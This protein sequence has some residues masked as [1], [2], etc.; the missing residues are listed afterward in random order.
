MRPQPMQAFPV[1]QGSRS[2]QAPQQRQQSPQS[3][4]SIRNVPYGFSADALV[5]L[6]DGAGQLQEQYDFLLLTYLEELD[7]WWAIVNFT[8]Q[9]AA[10]Q[11]KAWLH[12]Q[13]WANLLGMRGSGDG[14]A[15]VIA[16]ET[17]GRAALQ[18]V[19]GASSPAF[20][21]SPRR[22]QHV[23]AEQPSF[24][25]DNFAPDP[26]FRQ[27][28]M[29]LP[30]RSVS[31]AGGFADTH[32]SRVVSSSGGPQQGGRGRGRDV[33]RPQYRGESAQSQRPQA[34]PPLSRPQPHMQ[35]H[36]ASPRHAQSSR[37]EHAPQPRPVHS[38]R[39]EPAAQAKAAS[40][41]RPH[42]AQLPAK[43]GSRASAQRPPQ[44]AAPVR[45]K[46]QRSPEHRS[47][48]SASGG[49]KRKITPIV[50][51]RSDGA[52]A[53]ASDD[54]AAE[55]MPSKRPR[56]AAEPRR[57][58]DRPA[59]AQHAAA[60]PM[61]HKQSAAAGQS[62]PSGAQQAA[63]PSSVRPISPSGSKQ[64]QQRHGSPDAVEP[65]ANGHA[66]PKPES[67]HPHPPQQP[68]VHMP[69]ASIDAIMDS[70]EQ[71]APAP[72]QQREAQHRATADSSAPVPGSPPA[73][74]L[75]AQP[76]QAEGSLCVS[77]ID[78]R[79]HAAAGADANVE[80][81]EAPAD[82]PASIQE[83][84]GAMLASNAAAAAGKPAADVH[85][86]VTVIASGA[87]P[88]SFGEDFLALPS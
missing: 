25:Y 37:H 8:T 27:Q 87:E 2:Q 22:E 39:Y 30:P 67:E 38:S 17:N 58:R 29:V 48:P 1:Q 75:P 31:Y 18:H 6:L 71:Q 82:L 24:F 65:I 76:E 88:S 54:F 11:A 19:F 5:D 81:Q 49:S 60:A 14:I 3:T 80:M 21:E 86:V 45:Q 85:E 72:V 53:Q 73:E 56:Q 36:A 74:P 41:S 47:R 33:P 68:S 44:P 34:E 70:S 32:R 52:Q 35:E 78:S 7:S 15:A 20:Y 79:S 57:P 77:S 83:L 40:S 84:T 12:Q 28:S 9:Q 55:A 26:A 64:L 13:L 62:L 42:A 61:P 51:G 43:P 4:V 63:A 23:E 50:W 66:E 59:P 16:Y 10:Q 69:H 46:R